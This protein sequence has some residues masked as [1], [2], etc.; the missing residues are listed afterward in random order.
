[1]SNKKNKSKTSRV[2]GLETPKPIKHPK[3]LL[4]DLEKDIETRL[5][6]EGFNVSWG[7]FGS[8]YKVQKASGY[9]KVLVSPTLPNHEEQEIVIV[10]LNSKPPF[11]PAG[12][13]KAVAEGELDWW[14][15][16]AMESSIPDLE[17]WKELKMILTAS[18]TKVVPS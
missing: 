6:G 16:V 8:P 13:E 12:D 14:A 2:Q 3:I 1:M 7:S 11:F 17:S 5:K 4:L 18:S 15:T 9:Q 10:D